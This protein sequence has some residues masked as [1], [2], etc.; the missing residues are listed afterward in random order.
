MSSRVLLA[1]AVV[2][3]AA[4][5]AFTVLRGGEA[6][7]RNERETSAEDAVAN[8]RTERDATE[9]RAAVDAGIPETTSI[10]SRAG[11]RLTTEDAAQLRE[12]ILAARQQRLREAAVGA[13]TGEATA[14]SP[15]PGVEEER[16]PHIDREYIRDA[17]AQVRPLLGE[18]YELARAAAAEEGEELGEGRLQM[19]F[20]F[21]GEPD[22]GGIVEES[23]VLEESELR[24]PV[25]D[26]CFRETLYTLQLPAPEGGGRI[27][28]RYPFVLSQGPEEAGE[29][30]P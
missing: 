20:V 11:E 16:V 23:E 14:P 22:V 6:P 4:A 10:R 25:L 26:E 15:S 1:V 29:P 2:A 19:Q 3:L 28:V 7:E 12:A 18:C 17:V 13:A 27:T 9:A 8:E 30:P 24:H 21:A 5:V